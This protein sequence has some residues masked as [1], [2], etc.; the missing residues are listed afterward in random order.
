MSSGKNSVVGIAFG[1]LLAKGLGHSL[2]GLR[3]LMFRWR[4]GLTPL[5]F[6]VF[7]WLVAV[8]WRWLV[9]E[10]WPLVL[11]VGAG[12]LVLAALGPRLSERWH[13][14]VLALVPEGL[15]RGQS[16]VLDR[17]VERAYLA[18]L[19]GSISAWLALRITTG[20]TDLTEW[21]WEAGVVLFGGVWW[22]HRRIR[23]VGAANRFLR[24]WPKL[25]EGKTT[26]MELKPLV[27]SRPVF[28][29]GT[30]GTA[31][32]RVRLAQGVTAL[33]VS[34][35]TGALASFWSLRPGAVFA[36][37]DETNSRNVWLTILPRDP[38]KGKISHP[39]P[40]PGST[41]LAARDGK[42]EMG[43][44]A[45]NRPSHYRLQHTLLVGASGSGKSAWIESL[46]IWLI[47][48]RDVAVAGID[49]AS[50]ATLG[51]WRKVL[52]LPLA[53]D[54][55]SA[56][57]TLR[58]ILAFIEERERQLGIA[59]EEY[60]S[61]EDSFQ[62]T[63]ETPW[64]VLIIDEFPDLVMGDDGKP[65]K[66]AI[67]LLSRIAKRAR[68]AGVKLILCS[69]NGSKVDL[70]AKEIQA[71]FTCVI[72]LG[73]D[74]H[75]SRVLWGDL[76]RLGWNSTHL[77]M[78]QYLQRDAEHMQPDIAKGYWVPPRE[79]RTAVNQATGKRPQFEP[80]AWLALNGPTVTSEIAE[81]ERRAVPSDPILA[82]IHEQPRKADEL[83]GLP[84]M[85]SRATVYR[86]L[87]TFAE[88]GHAHSINGIWYPGAVVEGSVE[89]S[90]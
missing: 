3:K 86:R 30:R 34:K 15:D 42:L 74:Q 53:T 59:K 2:K 68:K 21:S 24:S 73:L 19:T 63:P 65:H 69:Q 23:T 6:G 1:I 4:R 80:G 18:A 39:M 8:L 27:G 9:P 82:A 33:H 32:I 81:A 50:G 72:G 5:W 75:A 44:H 13:R 78:G 58:R 47:A 77:R 79:R 11:L 90:A 89:V 57:E 51:I 12:G 87:K 76:A 83:A 26:S 85:P 56:L 54:M 10:W 16:G 48:F 37:E 71:Q 49:M 84:D 22:W 36:S 43:L 55:N 52:A 67:G 35:A 41:T 14:I 7:V 88:N 61:E 38:W 62:P 28:A 40:A 70:G 45:D 46:M 17:P 20:P 64:M 66:E 60:D 31:R 25:R 29:R